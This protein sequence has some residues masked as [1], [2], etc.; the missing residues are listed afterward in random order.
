MNSSPR[1]SN[2]MTFWPLLFDSS[3]AVGGFVIEAECVLFFFFRSIHS[4]DID[5]YLNILGTVDLGSIQTW[6]TERVSLLKRYQRT[7]ELLSH[8]CAR[9]N[10]AHNAIT[11]RHRD[12]I[13]SSSCCNSPC[14]VYISI[15]NLPHP[16]CQGP[17]VSPIVN[18]T[19]V[20]FFLSFLFF[21]SLG[22]YGV[23]THI[24]SLI[25]PQPHTAGIQMSS[26]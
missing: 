14:R 11:Q 23:V 2:S 20:S 10:S 15:R 17:Q 16:D 18:K 25:P 21:F 6:E 1:Q 26:R 8:L 22:T 3:Y 7:G 13:C 19:Y 4:M 24:F 12:K 9:Q 5:Q